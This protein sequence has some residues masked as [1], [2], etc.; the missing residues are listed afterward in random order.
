MHTIFSTSNNIKLNNNKITINGAL[1]VNQS[2]NIKFVNN[3]IKSK[4]TYTSRGTTVLSLNNTNQCEL[5]SNEY[6]YS[7]FK[8][9]SF[10]NDDNNGNHFLSEKVPILFSG[11][12]NNYSNGIITVGADY[13]Y[14]TFKEGQLVFYTTT[15]NLK[16]RKGNTMIVIS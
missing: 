12:L 5:N 14:S 4:E 15:N 2:S 8:P 13:G 6:V 3:K 7:T 9:V 16:I 1:C 10:Y 11:T